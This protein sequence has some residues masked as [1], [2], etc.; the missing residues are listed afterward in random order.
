MKFSLQAVLLLSISLLSLAAPAVDGPAGVAPAAPQ[1]PGDA[2]LSGTAWQLVEIASMNDEVFRPDD[3]SLYTIAFGAD[4]TAQVRADCNRATGGWTSSRSGQLQFG[5]LA[6]TQAM[7]PPGSLHDRFMAQLPWV[8]SYVMRDGHLFLATMA[9]GSII[10]FAPLAP[11]AA[12]VLGDAVRTS[13]ADEMQRIVLTRLFDHYAAQQGLTA[14]DA[15]IAAFL[16]HQR[17]GMQ[18]AGL[19]ADQDLSPE[20]AAQVERM[21]REMARSMIRQWKLNRALYTQYGGRVIFQQF[22]PE[23]LDAYRQFLEAGRAAGDFS[24]D[25]PDFEASFWRYF[26]DD[27]MHSFYPPGS[28]EAAQAFATPPWAAAVQEEAA[29]AGA[30]A[31]MSPDHGGPLN[32]TVSARHGLRLHEAPSISA[33]VVT[34]APSGAILDNL[35]CVDGEDRIWCDVQRFGGGP[36]GYAAADYLS[37]AVAPHGAVV[38]GPDDSATRA[39]RGEFDAI[40]RLPCAR[41]AGQPMT[42]CAFGV[43]RHG[44]GYAAVVVRHGDGFERAIFF[45]RGVAQGADTSQA[46]GYPPLRYHRVHDLNRV[47]VGPERYEIPDAVVFGG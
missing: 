6:A 11:V 27:S 16:E 9:D 36:R 10:E 1:P 44:G 45:R 29:A 18:A 17:R 41:F 12:T 43:A 32:W 26:T 47:S 37:P 21:R 38:T 13:D 42:Q 19:T 22:G 3:G 33:P 20:E 39:G 15:E 35:G 40:G 24:I 34:V 2:T 23:P 7:C 14:T 46:D 4:G 25:N 28:D 5:Q 31:P 8:R 30:A